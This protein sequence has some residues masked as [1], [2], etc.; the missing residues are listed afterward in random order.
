MIPSLEGC[1]TKA[2][3]APPHEV[4]LTLLDTNPV[5]QCLA[6]V[7]KHLHHN[8]YSS[9]KP[10]TVVFDESERSMISSI[11][12]TFV[13]FSAD[14]IMFSPSCNNHLI[15]KSYYVGLIHTSAV[16]LTTSGM[17]QSNKTFAM[18]RI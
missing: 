13:A 16:T 8:K 10:S 5:F 18:M 9:K 11:T 14:S 3:E 4:R 15:L 7:T 6:V 2:K 17:G 1:A 12:V